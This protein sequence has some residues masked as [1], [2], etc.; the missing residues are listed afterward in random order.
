MSVSHLFPNSLQPNLGIFVKERLKYVARKTNLSVIAPIPKFPF[1]NLLDK[2]Y[3]IDD[4]EHQEIVEGVH[5]YHPRYFMIPKYLKCLD[6][7]FY[8]LSLRHFAEDFIRV[9]KIDILDFH[10][11]YPD[12]IAGI[13]WARKSGKKIIVTVRGNEAIH[14]YEK[15]RVREI[16]KEQ[17]SS[18]HHIITVS[19]D[20][21]NKVINSYSVQ[22]DKVTVIP[23]GIDSTKFYPIEKSAA[24]AYCHL[25][26]NKRI[27]LTVSRLSSEKGLE[28]LIQAV[29]KIKSTDVML[30]I[31]GDGPLKGK[32]TNMVK[33]LGLAESVRFMGNIG[34]SDIIKWYNSADIFCLPSLWEGCPN[35]VIEALACGIPVVATNVGGIPDL[36]PGDQAGCLVPPGN[37]E[38]L[39]SAIDKSLN[40]HLD[41]R[42]IADCGSSNSWIN[43]AEKVIE[44]YNK[45]LS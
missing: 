27:I 17:L 40:A 4:I 15:T 31:I 35:V 41:R 5:V 1:M 20:L 26:D 34:H 24:K 2:Y 32:L 39:A 9:N 22:P 36:V 12:G 8:S 6:A 33:S 29:S 28:F 10:W 38:A 3:G 23:N 45:V 21:K 7:A 37:I 44:V 16:I 11:V 19:N 18:F 43:V 30:I 25:D 13:D 42:L 14:Y